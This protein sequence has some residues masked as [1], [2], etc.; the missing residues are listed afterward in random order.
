MGS[1]AC[2]DHQ[3]EILEEAP[4]QLYYTLDPLAS[5][6]GPNSEYQHLQRHLERRSEGVRSDEILDGHV[7]SMLDDNDTTHDGGEPAY[8]VLEKE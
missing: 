5:L 8:Y 2:K 6:G 3:Y 7:Y 1:Y 4:D